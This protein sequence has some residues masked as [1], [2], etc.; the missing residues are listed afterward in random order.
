MPAPLPSLPSK[1]CPCTSDLLSLL[2]STWVTNLGAHVLKHLGVSRTSRE[3]LPIS[4]HLNE[5]TGLAMLI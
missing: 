3:T 1:T 5:L 4:D 2:T